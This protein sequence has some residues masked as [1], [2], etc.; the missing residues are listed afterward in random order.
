V[1][2]VIY[3]PSA[4]AN[5]KTKQQAICDCCC[6]RIPGYLGKTEDDLATDET[7]HCCQDTA[8]YTGP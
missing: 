2:E 1:K 6:H 5:H 7:K 3:P 4:Y 8:K